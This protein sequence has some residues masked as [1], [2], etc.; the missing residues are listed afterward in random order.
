[1]EHGD[2][3]LQGS[4]GCAAK[5]D[6][7][8]RFHSLYDK[9]YREEVLKEA[10]MAVRANGGAAGIDGVA[11]EGIDSRGVDAYLKEIVEELKGKKYRPSPLRRMWIP[12]A[13]GKMRGLGMPTVKDRIVQAAA[14]LLLEPIFEQDFEPNSY[15]FRPDK[16]A[17]MAVMKVVKWLNFGYK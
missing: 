14:K 6:R 1:M 11:V 10:C 16:F 7:E 4:L 2:S 12:K 8:R 5:A 15:G 13:N 3:E 17:H 9:V